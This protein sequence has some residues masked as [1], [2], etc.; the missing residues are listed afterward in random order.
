MVVGSIDHV[1]EC[2]LA[3]EKLEKAN[4]EI[5][6]RGPYYTRVLQVLTCVTLVIIV[7]A[8]QWWLLMPASEGLTSAIEWFVAFL[9]SSACV[10]SALLYRAAPYAIASTALSC[11]P[12]LLYWLLM[13]VSSTYSAVL[14][15]N[16]NIVTP[17]ESM[18]QMSTFTIILALHHVFFQR[19][20]ECI[21]QLSAIMPETAISS[22]SN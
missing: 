8:L 19:T 2:A 11:A 16:R 6:L 15:R 21:Q 1:I 13:R 14:N 10:F 7:G 20:V 4:L 12:L 17:V 3:T 9:W 5:P 18:F 22:N